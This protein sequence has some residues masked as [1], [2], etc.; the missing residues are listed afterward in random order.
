MPETRFVDLALSIG[1]AHKIATLLGDCDLA[2]ARMVDA[3]DR[4]WAW[5]LEGQRRLLLKPSLRAL[6][7]LSTRLVEEDPKLAPLVAPAIAELARR[8]PDFAPFHARALAQ[9]GAF[10]A[11]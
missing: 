5:R 10:V 11:R 8:N 9:N 7:A 2:L 4:R 1:V 6:V 3:Q